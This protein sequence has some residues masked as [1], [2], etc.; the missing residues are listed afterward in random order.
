M[1]A[2]PHNRAFALS[3]LA[4]ILAVRAHREGGPLKTA[5]QRI[6]ASVD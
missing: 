4:E 2:P 6:H 5:K 1:N 3:I